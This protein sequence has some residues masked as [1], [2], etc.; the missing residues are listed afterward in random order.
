MLSKTN[1][2]KKKKDFGRVFKKGRGFKEDF[3]YLKI[4]K[5]GLGASRFAFIVSKDFSKK[6]VLRNKLRR[7]LSELTRLRLSEIKKG[8]DGVV[9]VLPGFQIMDFWEL[10]KIIQKLFKKA[11]IIE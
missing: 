7:S 1:R 5:N 6:A 10:E 2:L 9:V 8:I 11:K 3:L 4:V